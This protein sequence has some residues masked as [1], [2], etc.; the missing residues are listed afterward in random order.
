MNST[1][2][3]ALRR[4]AVDAD[5]TLIAPDAV[6]DFTPGRARLSAGLR[7]GGA[8]PAPLAFRTS[9]GWRA[10]FAARGLRLLAE[11]PIAPWWERLIHHPVLYVLERAG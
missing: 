4:A 1:M 8:M 2:V 11:R 3:A 10:L 5:V 9:A 7:H 6:G